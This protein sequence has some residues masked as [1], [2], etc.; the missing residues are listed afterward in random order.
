MHQ[1]GLR[2]KPPRKM[3]F[4][5]S[6]STTSAFVHSHTAV[7]GAPDCLVFTMQGHKSPSLLVSPVG[8]PRSAG[9]VEKGATGMRNCWKT[10][11]AVGK[12]LGR[13]Q[14]N[15]NKLLINCLRGQSKRAYKN[16]CQV[17]SRGETPNLALAPQARP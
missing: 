1:P 2:I 17:G 14:M 3:L 6:T 8:S 15:S 7:C 11:K 16:L 12:W 5:K 13:G 9:G 10:G 4:R